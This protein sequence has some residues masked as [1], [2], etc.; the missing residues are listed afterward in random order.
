MIIDEAHLLLNNIALIE[1]CREFRY[2]GLI[3]AT[4][5]DLLAFRFFRSFQHIV[6]ACK[7]NYDR[8]MLIYPI[9]TE[10]ALIDHVIEQ[11]SIYSKI[12]IKL[13][14]KSQ[15]IKIKAKLLEMNSDLQIALYN[16]D[17]K[18]IEIGADGLFNKPAITIVI[19]T[20]AIQSGQSIKEPNLLQI[21]VQMSYD[22]VSSVQQFIGRNRLP[23]SMTHL[24]LINSR[25]NE[26]DEFNYKT[27]NNRYKTELNKLRAEAY[28]ATSIIGWRNLLKGMGTIELSEDVLKTVK[29]SKIEFDLSEERLFK[30]KKA[31]YAYYAK[32]IKIEKLTLKKLGEEYEI[33]ERWVCQPH[34]ENGH[35]EKKRNYYLAKT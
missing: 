27:A 18:E 17:T 3:S 35:R 22:T 26:G 4:P 8:H 23:E 28:Y 16:A 20:S 5:K 21:F 32:Q 29:P 24:F 34:D 30:T 14:D 15:C 10:K 1:L 19:A 31:L 6:S 2:V 7:P 9:E 33:K 25:F 12:L 13:E 11:S